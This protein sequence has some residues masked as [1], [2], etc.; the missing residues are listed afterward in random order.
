ML[1]EGV[2][3]GQEEDTACWFRNMARILNQWFFAGQSLHQSHARFVVWLSNGRAKFELLLSTDR[4]QIA[5][6]YGHNA[7]VLSTF[8]LA[9]HA[10]PPAYFSL[11]AQNAPIF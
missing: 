10:L 8:E 3:P 4:Y 2:R 7:R 1:L 5:A 11:R 6:A 9:C